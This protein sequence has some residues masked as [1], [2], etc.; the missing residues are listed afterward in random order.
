MGGGWTVK[1]KILSIY[2]PSATSWWVGRIELLQHYITAKI[3]R[4]VK[5]YP[6]AQMYKWATA[7]VII[8]LTNCFIGGQT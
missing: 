7:I 8:K 6:E 5:Y 1:K 2:N 4:K 3:L